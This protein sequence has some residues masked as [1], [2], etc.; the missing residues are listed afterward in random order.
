M[1]NKYPRICVALA[2]A[3][4]MVACG[5]SDDDM[6][7]YVAVYGV[8][9]AGLT[10]TLNGG[11][12]VPVPVNANVLMFPTWVK[13]DSHFEIKI[14]DEAPN[15][16]CVLNNASGNTGSYAPNNIQLVCTAYTY[17]LGGKIKNLTSDGLVL[18]NGSDRKTFN[19]TGNAVG[20]AVDFNM[21]IAAVPATATTALIP[22][23]GKVAEDRPYGVLILQQPTQGTC[24]IEK[25]VNGASTGV[26]VMPKGPVTSIMIQC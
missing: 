11:E 22:E 8:T 14:K 20:A 26:G 3:F 9:K 23:S 12:P 4:G 6:Q 13:A 21:T 19:G 1:K 15:A 5:G 2:C 7:L 18:I 17:D 10:L 25:D 16:K 24:V